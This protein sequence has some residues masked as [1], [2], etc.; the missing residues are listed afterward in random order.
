M[1]EVPPDHPP[2]PQLTPETRVRDVSSGLDCLYCARQDASHIS[3]SVCTIARR[4][5]GITS[6]RTCYGD[7]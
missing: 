7:L 3:R 4:T 5:G 1:A 6:Y 2:P